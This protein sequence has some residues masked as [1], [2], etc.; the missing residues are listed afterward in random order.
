MTH[1]TDSKDAALQEIGRTAHDALAEMVD[2][3]QCDYERL[4]ELRDERERCGTDWHK[5]ADAAAELAEL[6]DSAG[7]C[8]DEDDA[9]QRIQEDPL[10]I[11]FR[12]DWCT[13]PRDFTPAEFCVL[14]STGGPAVRI[15]GELSDHGGYSGVRLQVQDWFTPWT[16]YRD[17]DVGMLETYLDCLGVAEM[18]ESFGEC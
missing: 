8:A 11:E 15:V 16:N 14:L 6:E 3:L 2:A 4:E 12:S 9:R 10:S 17:A 1:D 7:E 13:D 18:A 5:Y